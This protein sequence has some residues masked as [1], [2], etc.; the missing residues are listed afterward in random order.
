MGNRF[1]VKE[2]KMLDGPLLFFGGHECTEECDAMESAVAMGELRWKGGMRELRR[3]RSC[4][5]MGKPLEK[6]VVETGRLCPETWRSVPDGMGVEGGD[7][8]KWRVRDPTEILLVAAE[9]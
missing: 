9:H 8:K 7:K 6:G 3:E 4:C 2:E 5:G 1:L